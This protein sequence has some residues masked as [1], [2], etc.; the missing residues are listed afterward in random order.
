MASYMVKGWKYPK[1]GELRPNPGQPDKQRVCYGATPDEAIA[2][3][4]RE[5]D[6]DNP[7]TY[8]NIGSAKVPIPQWDWRIQ[9]EVL[10]PGDASPGPPPELP[11]PPAP[12][13]APA[14]AGS[15]GEGDK[16]KPK[17]MRKQ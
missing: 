13:S 4:R 7:G 16:P 15:G 5:Y 14:A 10:S 11:S 1:G 12:E 9:T 3:F 2:E 6:L 17:T 8:R